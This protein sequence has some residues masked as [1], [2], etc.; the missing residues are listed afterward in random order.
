V[1]NVEIFSRLRAEAAEYG[2]PVVGECFPN[3]SDFLS[4][5]EMH[6]QVL[7]GTR[8]LAELGADLI[9]TFYTCDFTSVINSCPI[10]I[11]GLGGHATPD[12]LDSL[13]LA[14]A[15][16]AD[17]ARGVVFGRNAI[18]RPDPKAYQRALCD[19]VKRRVTPAQAVKDHHL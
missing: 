16:I 10:P 18:Q 14:R 3:D 17:G 15:V 1:R 13:E 8:I 2:I 11:L 12:P 7:R 19:V 4:A 6:D 5:D 9:K